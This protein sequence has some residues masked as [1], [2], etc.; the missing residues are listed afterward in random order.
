M[1]DVIKNG[2]HISTDEE[3]YQYPSDPI[4]RERLEWFR[5]QKLA[6][7]IHFG[8]HAQMGLDCSWPLPEKSRWARDEIDWEDDLDV[9]RKQ[10]IDLNKSFNPMR[11]QP[12]E[13][14]D[15][16]AENGFR[17]LIFTTKHHDGFCLYDSKYTDYKVTAPDC[18]FHGHKYADITKN[19]FDAFRKKGLGIAAYFSKS[20]WHCPWYWAKGMDKPWGADRDPTYVPAEH[21]ELWE[22]FIE[23]THGQMMEIIEGYGKID[24][25]WLDGG[26]VSVHFG[27]DIRLGE[28]VEKA[29]R[30]QPWLITAD[31][32]VGGPHENYITPEQT[33]PDHVIE[34]PWESCVTHGTIWS[35]K[36]DDDYKS[37]RQLVKML[38]EVVSHGGN[39]ALGV[40]PQPDGRL[41]GRAMKEIR[42]LGEWLRVNGDAIYGT[43]AADIARCGKVMFTKKADTL[44]A[45]IPLEEGEELP[46]TVL[47][48]LKSKPREIRALG[49]ADAL[50]FCTKEDGSYVTLSD[51]LV[52]TSPYAIVFS[53]K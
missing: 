16:A 43:R 14:A 22:K 44:Y 11:F 46:D 50:T 47:I 36:Y 25:L 35:Y 1:G 40:G 48:P 39:L 7:L 23:F 26:Q 27:Q 6:L 31:R 33:I 29:R 20:D 41:P 5:D 3:R 37:S 42:G 32:C 13:W 2:V 45:L 53:I 12:D 38:I 34:A 17:Y 24:I 10:Y 4:I 15:F 8:P 18:P 28:L 30:I 21:P 19:I 52:G 9:F 49:H 51:S